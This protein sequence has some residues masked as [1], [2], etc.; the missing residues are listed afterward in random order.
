[1]G[2]SFAQVLAV[3]YWNFFIAS[4]IAVPSLSMLGQYLGWTGLTNFA[5]SKAGGCICSIACFVV[6]FLCIAFGMRVYHKIAFYV[7][8]VVIGGVVVLDV[9]LSITSKAG[10][11]N[12]FNVVAAKYHSLPYNS[13]ITAAGHAAGAAMPTTWNWADTFGATTGVFMLFIWSF[14]IAYIGGEV[15]RPDKTLMTANIFALAVPLLLA[16]WAVVAIGHVVD[17]NFLRAAA[18]QDYSGATKGYAL[19]FS[20]S[21]MSLAFIASGMNRVIGVIASLTFLATTIW[22]IVVSLIVPQRAMFAWGMDRMGPKWF[23]SINARFGAPVGMYA[24]VT[25]ISALG[26]VA[27][28]YLFPSVLSGLVASGMQLV[29]VFLVTSISAI[30]LPYRKKVAHIWDASPFS[31][32][33]VLGVPMITIAGIVELAYVLGLLYFAFFDTKTRDITGK[34]AILFV[35]AWVAGMCWY[36][37]WKYRSA[38]AG[39]DVAHY[40]YTALPPE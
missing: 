2:A 19:P 39:V 20:T 35:V 10:F 18:F 11:I 15:K 3:I 34:N 25:A 30:I 36:F 24:F 21:Y 7:L 5:S 8:G 14:G 37:A 27:Y 26:A 22:L 31:N 17:F 29:S 32:W 33:K 1:M 4:W 13:F 40:T 38:R 6:A 12:H 9:V 28:F 23:T 16:I